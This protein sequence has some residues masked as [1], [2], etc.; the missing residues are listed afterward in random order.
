MANKEVI[1]DWDELAPTWDVIV[2]TWEVIVPTWDVVW[3]WHSENDPPNEESE[4]KKLL[5]SA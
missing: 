5:P 3:E 4:E 2:P 1:T